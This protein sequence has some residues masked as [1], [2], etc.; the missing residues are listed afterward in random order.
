MIHM[1]N[2][3]QFRNELGLRYH[4]RLCKIL[5]AFVRFVLRQNEEDNEIC[6]SQSTSQ[7]LVAVYSTLEQY[8]I[9]H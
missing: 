9:S 5:V 1:V 8:K 2:D 6:N 3:T 4:F 7:V